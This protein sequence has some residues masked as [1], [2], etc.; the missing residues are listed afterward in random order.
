MYTQTV[1]PAPEL[2]SHPKPQSGAEPRP[3]AEPSAEMLIQYPKAEPLAVALPTRSL[4]GEFAAAA[5]NRRSI[6]LNRAQHVSEGLAGAEWLPTVGL[7]SPLSW[8][9]VG[10][11]LALLA[12]FWSAILF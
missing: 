1:G 2:K 7:G 8:V 3:K 4:W 10:T 9:V 11:G 5:R 6:R 12:G